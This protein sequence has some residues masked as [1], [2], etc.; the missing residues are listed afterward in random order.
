VI[1]IETAGM[2]SPLVLEYAA[3]PSAFDV[4]SALSAREDVDGR[5][6]LAEHPVD[7]TYVKDYDAI[8]E[9]PEDWASRWDT[10]HWALFLAR[11]EGRGVGAAT[12]AWGTA[13]L[14]ML[15]SRTD[16]A[17]LWDIRVAPAFR[18]RGIGRALF[19]AV[20]V[21]ALARACREL[22]VETQNVNVAA[23]R[24]Y[25][26]LGCQLRIVR[27]EAYPDCPGEAQFLWYKA[28]PHSQITAG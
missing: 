20:Q 9:R 4:T 28:L 6:I 18:G 17:V 2:S 21:W 3:I 19:E 7:H 25:A 27:E 11:V 1:T 22:K 26:A 10:S 14:D 13:D 15:E 8:S 24:F 23:C 16:L 12:G 5:F